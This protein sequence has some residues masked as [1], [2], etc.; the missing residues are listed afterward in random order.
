MSAQNT[1][2]RRITGPGCSWSRT[3]AKR[4]LLLT[5]VNTFRIK[6]MTFSTEMS[7]ISLCPCELNEICHETSLVYVLLY[8]LG[9]DRFLTK[10]SQKNT[11][12]D[13]KNAIMYTT[14]WHWIIV[15]L[16]LFKQARLS[17][18]TRNSCFGSK[19]RNTMLPQAKTD[20]DES[21]RQSQHK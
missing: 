11:Q 19:Q 14:S 5:D 15:N 2:F 12:R 18:E 20:K 13:Y 21:N 10:C 16:K 3:S 8:F 4:D 9:K 7:Q 6:I 1:H 17:A